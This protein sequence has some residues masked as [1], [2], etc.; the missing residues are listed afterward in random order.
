MNENFDAIYKTLPPELFPPEA[1]NTIYQVLLMRL[2]NK[3]TA[4][5]FIGLSMYI[6]E[7]YDE[8]KSLDPTNEEI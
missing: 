2:A 1:E 7:A 6:L 5:G 4:T 3:I 8:V